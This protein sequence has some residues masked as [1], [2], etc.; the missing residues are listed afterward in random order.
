LAASGAAAK[1]VAAAVYQAVNGAR[2]AEQA[3]NMAGDVKTSQAIHKQSIVVAQATRGYSVAPSKVTATAIVNA[4]ERLI[5][6]AVAYDV[7]EAES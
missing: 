2:S 6:L 4:L 7:P 3:A 1:R 5:T